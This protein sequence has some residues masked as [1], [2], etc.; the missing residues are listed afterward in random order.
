MNNYPQVPH[1]HLYLFEDVLSGPGLPVVPFPLPKR[2]HTWIV[3]KSNCRFFLFF[4]KKIL[5]F[6]NFTL[7]RPTWAPSFRPRQSRTCS[8]SNCFNFIL[9]FRKFRGKGSFPP[10]MPVA[11]SAEWPGELRCWHKTFSRNKTE[12]DN[13]FISPQI[14]LYLVGVE[15]VSRV[16]VS[17]KV[18]SAWIGM[19]CDVLVLMKA[20]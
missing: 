1:P 15:P 13:L 4:L 8:K 12:N 5:V 9:V 14:T 7:S 20:A 19:Y 17:E 18:A 10:K 3:L 6:G 11:C 2:I 16:L